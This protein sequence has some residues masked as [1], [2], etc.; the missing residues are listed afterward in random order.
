MDTVV[1]ALAS[2]VDEDILEPDAA[3][4]H[5]SGLDHRRIAVASLHLLAEPADDLHRG[6]RHLILVESRLAGVDS[7]PAAHVAE[8]L[9]QR[10]LH[11]AGDIGD[12]LG[13]DGDHVELRRGGRHVGR[14]ARH[15]GLLFALNRP[16]RHR[17]GGLRLVGHRRLPRFRGDCDGRRCVGP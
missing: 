2:G 4:P 6:D 8:I 17:V 3:R 13:T 16:R 15:C 12:D 5:V 11:L 14:T 10:C 1:T 9:Q 7:R